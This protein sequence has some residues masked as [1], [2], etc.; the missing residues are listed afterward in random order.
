MKK[1]WTIII[2]IATAFVFSLGCQRGNR[3]HSA[4]SV[5]IEKENASS[6]TE[7]LTERSEDGRVWMEVDTV[8]H[9]LVGFARVAGEPL[10]DTLIHYDP[11]LEIYPKRV[12]S[13]STDNGKTF[14]LLIYSQGHLLYCDEAMTCTFEEHGLQPA[15]LFSTEG[16]KDSVISCMWYDQLVEASEG[17]PFDDFDEDRFGIHY[18]QSTKRL[19]SPI[20]ENHEEGS[21]YENCLR[22]TGRYTVFQFN[23]KEFVE[24]GE[25]GAWWLNPE[26]RNY[27]RTVSNRKTADGI[28]Q[29]DLMADGTLRRTFWK[30][31]KTLD[32]LRYRP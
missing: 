27:K 10:V 18:D 6:S 25:D 20:M 7:G 31:A 21:G 5:A 22:Y 1:S 30:G 8:S 4:E 14:Y 9:A 23:G 17:F 16:Q 3:V 13:I 29:V 26:L 24:A 2:A 11:A 12:H 19:Y 32:D 15:S 28:E